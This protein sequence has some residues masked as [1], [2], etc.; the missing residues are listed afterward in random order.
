MTSPRRS[1]ESGETSNASS[2][3]RWRWSRRMVIAIAWLGSLVAVASCAIERP[4]RRA[5]L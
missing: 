5:F 4:L 1:P 2:A 3:T